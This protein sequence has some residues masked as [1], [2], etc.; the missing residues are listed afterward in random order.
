MSKSF[1]I[2][3]VIF[4][5]VLI[6]GSYLLIAGGKQKNSGELPV[7]YNKKDKEKPKAEIKEAVK[8]LGKMKVSEQKAADFLLSNTGSKPLSLFQITSSCG[9]TVGQVILD[10]KIS[11][12]FGMHADNDKKFEV[13]PGK[14]A[15]VRVT[16]RPYIMPVSGRIDREVFIETNDPENPRLI[17]KVTANVN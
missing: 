10:G 15:T 8:D 14:K 17:F 6:S 16:Y 1:I 2:G 7:V 4:S 13:A 11:E 3:I 5:I 9:C 12:E